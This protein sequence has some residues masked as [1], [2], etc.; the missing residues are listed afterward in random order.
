MAEPSPASSRPT[1][2]AVIVPAWKQA[3]YLAGAVGSVLAQEAPFGVGAVI[4]DD[5]CPDPETA[6]V[7]R[8]LRDANP[9]RIEFLRQ[10]NGGVAAARNTGVRRAIRRWPEVEAFFFL[11]ADNPFPP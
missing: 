5:G 9:D 2:I 11:D 10:A 6:R 1:R 7:G 8:T 3:R 4:V